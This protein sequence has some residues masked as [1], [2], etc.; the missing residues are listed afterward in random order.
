MF[1][2]TTL[3]PSTLHLEDGSSMILWNTGILPHF[4]IVS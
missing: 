3:S 4:Y 2:R 1:Q